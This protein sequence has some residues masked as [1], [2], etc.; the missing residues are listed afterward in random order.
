MQGGCSTWRCGTDLS[1]IQ[2]LMPAAPGL[3]SP[4]FLFCRELL[5]W[6]MWPRI[7]GASH[8]VCRSLVFAQHLLLV[9]RCCAH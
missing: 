2:R 9:A 4:A 5:P 7:N 3:S 8:G 6:N 1:G